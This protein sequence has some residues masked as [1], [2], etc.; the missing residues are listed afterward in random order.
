M[1]RLNSLE[2]IVKEEALKKRSSVL[3]AAPPSPILKLKI[4]KLLLDMKA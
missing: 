1:R 3:E 2:K 4:R